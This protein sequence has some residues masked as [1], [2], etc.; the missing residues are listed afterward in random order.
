MTYNILDG[1]EGRLDLILKVIKTENP[2]FLVVNEVNG[3]EKDDKINNFSR[4]IRLPY[5]K[6]S[7]SGEYDYHTAIFSKYPFK[8]I[9]EIR[10]LRNAGT[11][12]VIETELGEI[13]IIGVHLAPYTEE[14]RLTEINLI[15]NQQKQYQNKI[16]MGDMNS[17]STGD[18]YNEEIIKGFNENQLSKFTTNGKFSFDVINKITSSSYIDTAEVFRKESV[19]TVPTEITQDE[20]NLTEM[21]LDYIFVS[22]SL[23]NKIKSYSV[24]K[25]NLTNKASDHYPVVIEIK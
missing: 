25:N 15:I 4:E 10:P 22:D 23:K 3:F 9:K 5:Y 13:S 12:V 17:L 11:L 8:E 18:G 2:D 1:G 14:T 6:L 16:L 19:S 7:L 20:A 21:R 24:V